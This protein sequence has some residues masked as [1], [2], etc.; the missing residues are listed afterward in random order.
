MNILKLLLARSVAMRATVVFLYRISGAGDDDSAIN[1]SISSP[2]NT[3]LLQAHHA[4]Y[5][6]FNLPQA[7]VWPTAT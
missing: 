4:H 3:V 2:S 1:S 6:S 5:V 7:K